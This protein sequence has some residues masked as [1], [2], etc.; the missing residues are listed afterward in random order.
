MHV[1]G[2]AN[3]H[4]R[5]CMCI[6]PC[7]A[8]HCT[9]EVVIGGEHNSDDQLLRG[10]SCG[11]QCS[12]AVQALRR[13][14]ERRGAEAAQ[15]DADL[16]ALGYEILRRALRDIPLRHLVQQL[17]LGVHLPASCV[18]IVAHRGRWLPV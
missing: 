14:T 11:H 8:L 6:C 16:D 3:A 13:G 17:L 10:D 1:F 5:T 7:S 18:R 15:F 4:V 2:R 9:K 12:K